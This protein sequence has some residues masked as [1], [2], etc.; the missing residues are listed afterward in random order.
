MLNQISVFL[1]NIPGILERFTKVLMD[2][3]INMRA[4]TVAE[5]ADFGILRMLVDKEEE[6]IDILRDHDYLVSETKV[7]AVEVPDK[8][9][10][11]HGIAK[12]LAD[13]DINIEY[14]YSALLVKDEAIIILR[15]DDNESAVK[16]LKDN[17]MKVL[18]KQ[19]I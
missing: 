5:T 4:L 7:I 17:N 9:G 15:V 10:G 13:E 1:D 19:I 16:V 14:I 8:P 11:L 18:D 6:C 12:I 3:G 2:N